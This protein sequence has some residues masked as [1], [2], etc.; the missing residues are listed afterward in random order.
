MERFTPAQRGD[1][2]N[3]LSHKWTV[4]AVEIQSSLCAKDAEPKRYDSTLSSLDIYPN[5]YFGKK[6]GDA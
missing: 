5:G 2:A 4:S 6:R 3:M 1:L